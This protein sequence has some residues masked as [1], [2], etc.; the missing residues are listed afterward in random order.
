MHY[1]PNP[2][3]TEVADNSKIIQDDVTGFIAQSPTILH[4][5]MHWKEPGL[6]EPSGR[7]WA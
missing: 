1:N 5:N 2:T 6:V 7:H 3:V 4:L